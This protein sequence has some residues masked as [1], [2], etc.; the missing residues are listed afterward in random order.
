MVRAA[1][2]GAAETTGHGRIPDLS[3][4]GL[5]ADASLNA[6]LDAGLAIGD[7][8]GVA[9]GYLSP[10][11]LAW[12]LGIEA[13]WLDGTSVGGCSWLAHVRHAAA[14]I[15][16]GL[17]ST[18]LIAHGESGRSFQGMPNY[19]MIERQSLSQ[20][21]DAPYGWT[22]G[23][24][25]FGL[26]ILRYMHEFGMTEEQLANVA[27]VQREWAAR[28]ERAIHKQPITASEVLA[29][30]MVAYPLR[31]LMCCLV[32]DGGGALVLTRA[33]RA[34]HLGQRPVFLLG[35]GEAS[36]SYLTGIAQV[37]DPLRPSFVRRS[38]ELAFL[39][40]GIGRGAVTPPWNQE[41]L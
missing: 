32:T 5:A 19:N 35:S 14:A 21:F 40:A 1:I 16:A 3:A 24:A 25:M 17:C 27:V 41:R 31:R 29:S 30:P 37:D 15:E 20:Q 13:N 26:P 23:A 4:L 6:L 7:I 10:A 36:G 39:S 34:G 18:V 38:A 33:D 9:T 2:V 12:Y 28:N 8:D 11:E 22:G